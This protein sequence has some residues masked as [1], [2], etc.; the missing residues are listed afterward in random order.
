MRKFYLL[1]LL[2]VFKNLAAQNKPFY[3]KINFINIKASDVRLSSALNSSIKLYDSKKYNN[4]KSYNINGEIQCVHMFR[5]VFVNENNEEIATAPFFVS[6]GKN[7]V[8][9]FQK[10]KKFE[11][12][13]LSIYQDEYK[14]NYLLAL[15]SINNK[16]D[17]FQNLH[18]T[19]SNNEQDKILEQ[20]ELAKDSIIYD[21]ALHNQNSFVAAWNLFDRINRRSFKFKIIHEEIYFKEPVKSSLIGVS[22]KKVLSNRKQLSI[23]SLFPNTLLSF[24]ETAKIEKNEYKYIFVDFWYSSCSPCL[25]QMSYLSTLYKKYH[26]TKS[27]EIVSVSIDKK[28]KQS[29]MRK[30]IIENN[31]NW[32][33]LWDLNQ[34]TVHDFGI[35]FFPT[36]F[37]LDSAYKILSINISLEDL[38][39]ILSN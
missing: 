15:N 10:N 38:E 8:T 31:M 12:E 18:N 24:N 5:I 34:I 23:G 28:E 20:Y 11:I 27:L 3:L 7:T 33:Q 35:H 1:L 22:C 16:I 17:N 30:A 32:L 2:I 6:P 9:I 37:L 25:A 26:S 19:D 4:E 21:Y 36:N 14:E 29:E 39:K 13:D